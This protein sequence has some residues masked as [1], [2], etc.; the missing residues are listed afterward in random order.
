MLPFN[1]PKLIDNDLKESEEIEEKS[2]NVPEK[3][4]KK[5]QNNPSRINVK[6][7]KNQKEVGRHVEI[8]KVSEMKITKPD[9]SI[10]MKNKEKDRSSGKPLV[11]ISEVADNNYPVHATSSSQQFFSKIPKPVG[12]QFVKR[13]ENLPVNSELNYKALHVKLKNV[14]TQMLKNGRIAK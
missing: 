4:V 2:N 10:Y 14:N 1:D 6:E 8:R 7:K 12:D 13:K 11:Q 9:F 5:V 3:N